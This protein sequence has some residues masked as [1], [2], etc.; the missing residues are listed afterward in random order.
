MSPFGLPRMIIEEIVTAN[1]KF[2]KW[3][4]LKEKSEKRR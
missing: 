1:P 2:Q 3:L 4:K